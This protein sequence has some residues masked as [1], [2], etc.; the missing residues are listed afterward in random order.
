M[1]SQIGLGLG[2]AGSGGSGVASLMEILLITQVQC[3]VRIKP[4][5][6][7]TVSGVLDLLLAGSGGFDLSRM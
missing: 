4:R 5:L 1:V 6:S 2:L 3:I 7:F